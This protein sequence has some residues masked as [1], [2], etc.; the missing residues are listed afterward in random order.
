M[1]TL[2][3]I[4]IDPGHGGSD[5]GAVSGTVLEKNLVLDYALM[6]GHFLREL[7]Y[8]TVF[9]RSTDKTLTQKE[10]RSLATRGDIL[11]SCHINAAASSSAKGASV[12]YRGGVVDSKTLA[13]YVYEEIMDLKF[14]TRYGHGVFADTERYKTGFYMLRFASKC[15]CKSC[16]LVEPGFLSNQE[17]RKILMDDRKRNLLAKAIA[18]GI[19][20]YIKNRK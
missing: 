7:G 17:N 14:F 2:P 4:V 9:T 6:L 11:V 13:E 20:N 5:P 8:K 3:R 1:T 16:I 12:W 19:D 10:R 15:G 18:N